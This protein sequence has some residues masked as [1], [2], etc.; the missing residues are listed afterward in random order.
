MQISPANFIGFSTSSKGQKTFKSFN[1]LLNQE[2]DA[3]FFEA[4]SEEI[5]ETMQLAKKAFPILAQTTGKSRAVFLRE[6]GNLLETNRKALVHQYSLESGLKAERGNVELNRTIWQLETFARTIEQENWDLLQQDEADLARLPNPKPAFRKVAFPLGPVVV[7]GAS[8]FPFA[9][10]TV[11]G[12]T[13]S[14]LAAGCPVIVKSHPMHAGTSNLVAQLVI[15]AAHKT[16]MPDGTFS[17]LNAIDFEVGTQLVLHPNTKAVGFTGSFAGGM[18]L[19]KL[20]QQRDEPIPVF[21]EMGSLNPIVILPEAMQNDCTKIAS[22]I[23]NSITQS[24]GQ[25]CTTPGLLFVLQH[26]HLDN[27]LR[28]LKTNFAIVEPQCMLHPNIWKRYNQGRETI[29]NQEKVAKW[30]EVKT[31]KPNFGTPQISK[32]DGKTFQQNR[33]LQEEVFGPHSLLI[34]CEDISEL[35]SCIQ[36]LSGQLT[37]SIFGSE[38]EIEQHSNLLFDL[39]QIAGRI[40]L[41]GVPTGVEVCDSMHHGGPFPATTDSRFTAVG[42]DAIWRFLR[43][44]SFQN[45]K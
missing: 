38:V 8:N 34:I 27:F 7:F 33:K 4:T 10:S 13:A 19:Q 43:P 32:T 40:I 23:A 31:E 1:P 15:E 37:A 16:G 9:Y 26:E 11:G 35:Q 14:A 29:S 2:M 6:I 18:A 17:H 45:F 21:A 44:I 25:F 42:K 30:I 41:N 24:A 12:D 20:A 22:Q 39:Q 3:F 5:N 28:E 36:S